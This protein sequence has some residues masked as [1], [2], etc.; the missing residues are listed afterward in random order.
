MVVDPRY[1]SL[2]EE[3]L[4]PP[5]TEAEQE[6]MMLRKLKQIAEEEHARN[7]NRSITAHGKK[8]IVLDLMANRLAPDERR[9]FRSLGSNISTEDFFKL[10]PVFFDDDE[11]QAALTEY[12]MERLL[13][14]E[15]DA[16]VQIDAV[17]TVCGR[18]YNYR[19]YNE[20]LGI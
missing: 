14:L 16:G 20:S 9:Q 4:L 6:A 17:I 15:D 1:P 12:T 3:D 18:Q 11:I 8:N 7:L 19:C 13:Q 10:L 2:D 5:L